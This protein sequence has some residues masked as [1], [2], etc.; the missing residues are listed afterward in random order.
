MNTSAIYTAAF[1]IVYKAFPSAFA[2]LITAEIVYKI[3]L[4]LGLFA[5]CHGNRIAVLHLNRIPIEAGDTFQIDNKA[6]VRL[7]K[8]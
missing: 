1:R 3:S 8:E 5:K 7:V 2:A 6:F 4:K